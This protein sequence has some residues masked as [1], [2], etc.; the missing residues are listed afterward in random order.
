M[1]ERTA[2]Y[3]FILYIPSVTGTPLNP[4]PGLLTE[5]SPRSV[6]FHVSQLPFHLFSRFCLHETEGSEGIF[7]ILIARIFLWFFGRWASFTLSSAVANC[8]KWCDVRDNASCGQRMRFAVR[9]MKSEFF[10]VLVVTVNV[11]TAQV[12]DSSPH[13][14][15]HGDH[16]IL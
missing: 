9:E 11:S 2:E 13:T 12:N 5:A 3:F 16:F 8:L 1:G 10:C 7:C 15:A 4:D 6:N 14:S